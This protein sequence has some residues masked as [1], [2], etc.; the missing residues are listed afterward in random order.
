MKVMVLLTKSDKLKAWASKINNV[1][2]KKRLKEHGV[3]G[4]V[5]TFSS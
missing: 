2:F 5:Q 1:P 3:A 4:T